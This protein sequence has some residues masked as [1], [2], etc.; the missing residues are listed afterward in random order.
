MGLFEKRTP[1]IVVRHFP[2]A[3]KPFQK[4]LVHVTFNWTIWPIL[5]YILYKNTDKMQ[6][7]IYEYIWRNLATTKFNLLSWNNKTE[8][9]IRSD[10]QTAC[11]YYNSKDIEIG[12]WFP[13]L[14]VSDHYNPKKSILILGMWTCSISLRQRVVWACQHLMLHCEAYVALMIL[15]TLPSRFRSLAVHQSSLLAP[16]HSK[17]C[18]ELY[19]K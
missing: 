9:W 12:K 10:F 13:K 11:C 5:F 2:E 18:P 15:I 6:K 17:N 16:L 7:I 14:L 4:P 1:F 19:I 8:D 3:K